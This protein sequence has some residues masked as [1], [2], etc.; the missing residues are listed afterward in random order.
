MLFTHETGEWEPYQSLSPTEKYAIWLRWCQGG[1]WVSTCIILVWS[2]VTLALVVVACSVA[3][4]V[5]SLE[6]VYMPV[7]GPH[8]GAKPKVKEAEKASQ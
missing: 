5:F 2:F 8:P 6:G 4:F 1:V 3:I 7:V